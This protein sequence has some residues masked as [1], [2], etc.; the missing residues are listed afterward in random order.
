MKNICTGNECK[1][2]IMTKVKKIRFKQN[3]PLHL[4]KKKPNIN[5]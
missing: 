4:L 5:Q 2:W 3:T 1:T